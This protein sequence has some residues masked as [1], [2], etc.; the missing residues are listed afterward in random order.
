MKKY[1]PQLKRETIAHVAGGKGEVH[2]MHILDK[3]NACGAGRLFSIHT[4]MPGSS[5]GYHEHRDEFE[6]YY[7]LEGSAQVVEDNM[8]YQLNTG[9]MMQCCSG[10]GHSIENISDSPVKFLALIINVME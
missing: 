5:I 8:T 1:S 2:M 4:L 7:I 9:D 10:S 6:V 3:E